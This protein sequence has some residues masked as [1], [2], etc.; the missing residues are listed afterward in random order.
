MSTIILDRVTSR[1]IKI[2]DLSREKA[3]NKSADMKCP[4]GASALA[5]FACQ[6]AKA[7]KRHLEYVHI[8]IISADFRL[9]IRI[10]ACTLD[11]E[12]F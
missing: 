10:R 6:L 8:S 9:Q 3:S 4:E 1:L 11:P 5:L 12:V 7:G 2:Q